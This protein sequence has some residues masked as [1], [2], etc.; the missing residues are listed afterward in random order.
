M[1]LLA[2]SRVLVSSGLCPAFATPKTS[3]WTPWTPSRPAH[4]HRKQPLSDCH[5]ALLN[6][7]RPTIPLRLNLVERPTLTLRLNLVP[8]T[9]H[10]T[11][12][13]PGTRADAADEV[14]TARRTAADVHAPPCTC[15]QC[16]ICGRYFAKL[17]SSLMPQGV[18][19][20]SCSAMLG[21][22]LCDHS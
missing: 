22:M 19:A 10:R 1:D 4:H 8:S 5:R 21:Y 14:P 3:E 2:D 17:D 18:L 16:P 12:L 13:F 6:H 9:R 11:N 20:M 7:E 15:V